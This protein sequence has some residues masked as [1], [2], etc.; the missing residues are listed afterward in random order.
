M[1]IRRSAIRGVSRMHLPSCPR[2]G[3][4]CG[5]HA[6]G[7]T[8]RRRPGEWRGI[9]RVP[10]VR[11]AHRPRCERA[12]HAECDRCGIP[13]RLAPPGDRGAWARGARREIRRPFRASRRRTHVHPVYSGRRRSRLRRNRR[14]RF[15]RAEPARS[16]EHHPPQARAAVLCDQRG[17]HPLGGRYLPGR[18]RRRGALPHR[19]YL[20]GTAR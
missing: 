6:S 1:C 2:H 10:A 19:R 9:P 11:Y 15:D 4:R 13:A 7:K 8:L 20:R 3:S 12:G 14:R 17:D 5:P 16:R 18:K